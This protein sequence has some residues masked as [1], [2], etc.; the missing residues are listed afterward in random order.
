MEYFRL[1]GGGSV[2]KVPE[3]ADDSIVMNSK[4]LALGVPKTIE[5]ARAST[6]LN[7]SSPIQ[8]N[9]QLSICK[10]LAKIYKRSSSAET[11]L[12]HHI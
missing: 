11:K 5:Y 1:T 4:N 12:V 3:V 2:D 6:F 10:G 7:S 8:R 9:V